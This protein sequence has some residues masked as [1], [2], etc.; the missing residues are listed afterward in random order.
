MAER[1]YELTDYREWLNK[2]NILADLCK[3]ELTK[4]QCEAINVMAH[5]VQVEISKNNLQ[6][7]DV[8]V[9]DFK[10]NS[11]ELNSLFGVSEKTSSSHI[12]KQIEKLNGI[13][14]GDYRDNS[15][16]E[17]ITVFPYIKYDAVNFVLEFNI[18]SKI[19]EFMC[20]KEK[21]FT[22]L[23]LSK[24]REYSLSK[25]SYNLLEVIYR[26][27][28]R[29]RV[30]QYVEFSVDEFK[31]VIG[32]KYD[33]SNAYF[34][35]NIMLKSIKEIKDIVGIEI[36]YA[37][38]DSLAYRKIRSLRL[39]FDYSNKNNKQFIQEYEA[40]T[41]HKTSEEICEIYNSLTVEQQKEI[42]SGNCYIDNITGELKGSKKSDLKLPK[43]KNK[44]I[45]SKTKNVNKLVKIICE[46]LDK[47]GKKYDI[48]SVKNKLMSKTYEEYLLTMEK[49]ELTPVDKLNFDSGYRYFADDVV[50]ES[51]VEIIED[52]VV[53]KDNIEY[54]LLKENDSFT[55]LYDLLKNS[56]FSAE[57]NR[58]NNYN[59]YLDSIGDYFK[60]EHYIYKVNKEEFEKGFRFRKYK[61]EMI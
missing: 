4:L 48:K 53:S 15:S 5:K 24:L 13:S 35:N 14:F 54:I 8:A 19:G 23:D 22:R 39:Y 6:H 7:K 59:S 49:F 50:C 46:K 42:D 12:A 30:N 17:V 26:N 10:I 57:I 43:L 1:N 56:K 61:Q 51:N 11:N 58:A 21:N 47:K 28:Y 16:F 3:E 9:M 25:Y 18:N 33:C 55:A 2:P 34:K 36:D 52:V 31:R 41:K 37:I 45:E 29:F 60:T 20:N 38:N 27:L 40:I 32:A 44:P